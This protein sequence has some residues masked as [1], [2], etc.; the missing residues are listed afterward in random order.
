MK[1]ARKANSRDLIAGLF[2]IAFFAVCGP[3]GAQ[4]EPQA[5]PKNDEN[6]MHPTVPPGP[7]SKQAPLGQT[8]SPGP[9]IKPPAGVDPGIEKPVT[10]SNID[11]TPVIKP[12]PNSKNPAVPE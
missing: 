1:V 5:V 6:G 12:P 2:G 10:Q 4:Q 7:A 9:V 3:A 11:N 8:Q